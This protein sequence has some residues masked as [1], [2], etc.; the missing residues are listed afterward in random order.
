MT[1]ANEIASKF[2]VQALDHAKERLVFWIEDN[3]LNIIDDVCSFGLVSN[4][5]TAKQG[6]WIENV[7]KATPGFRNKEIFCTFDG[8]RVGTWKLREFNYHLYI[9]F[10]LSVEF[11]TRYLQVDPEIVATARRESKYAV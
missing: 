4:L 3:N 8:E 1:K 10:E 11:V 2:L 6:D 9:D 7:I 5:L